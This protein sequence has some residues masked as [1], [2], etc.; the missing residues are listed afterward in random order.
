MLCGCWVVLCEWWG[1]GQGVVSSL[2]WPIRRGGRWVSARRGLGI[3]A[4]LLYSHMHTQAL[5]V[6]VWGMVDPTLEEVPTHL[7]RLH[8]A[9]IDTLLFRAVLCCAPSHRRLAAPQQL[10]QQQWVPRVV[11]VRSAPNPV[12]CTWPHLPPRL[13]AAARTANVSVN[14]SVNT[15]A[16][17]M[18]AAGA[19]GVLS[20][21][22][23]P[24]AAA[25]AAQQQ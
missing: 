1:G 13:T 21:A 25:A 2:N 4:R 20:G 5:C 23:R 16:V 9:S 3:V 24:A 22:A 12:R 11:C 18:A 17:W 14:A 8:T 15:A 10:Q 7:S 19:G 6:W